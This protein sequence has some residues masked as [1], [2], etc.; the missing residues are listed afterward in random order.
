MKKIF[1][2][3]FISFFVFVGCQSAPV[4]PSEAQIKLFQARVDSTISLYDNLLN[5]T[6]EQKIQIR[7]IIVEDLMWLMNVRNQMEKQR[8][9]MEGERHLNSN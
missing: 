1:L 5:L 3:L 9:I 2:L 6:E 8:K 7:P 4:Q